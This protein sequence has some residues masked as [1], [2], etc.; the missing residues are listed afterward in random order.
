MGEECVILK[1]RVHGAEIGGQF[2][3][4]LPVQVHGAGIGFFQ[5]ADDPQK[6][7]FSAAGRAENGEK[8]PLCNGKG[9]IP[10]DGGFSEGFGQVGESKDVG[11]SELR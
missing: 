10:D 3:H 8:F 2:C 4:I 1:Y 9:K 5:T 6:G 11:H 7:G